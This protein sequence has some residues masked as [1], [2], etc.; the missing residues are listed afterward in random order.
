MKGLVALVFIIFLY[1][2]FAY[3]E[4]ISGLYQE[5]ESR[6]KVQSTPYLL[7]AFFLV[8]VNWWLEALK[9]QYLMKP[10]QAT[11]LGTAFRAVLIGISSS[12]FTPNRIGEYLG[13]V[14]ATTRKHRWKAAVALS[15]GSLIQ[16]AIISILGVIALMYFFGTDD[17]HLSISVPLYTLFALLVFALA[18]CLFFIGP[19]VNSFQGWIEK[20]YQKAWPQIQFLIAFQ[21]QDLGVIFLLTSIR[22][23]VY[24]VQY[25][26]LIRFFGVNVDSDLAICM[27]LITYL[28]QT[29]LPL[30]LLL[31]LM[32]RGEI[33]LL[34]WNYLGVNELSILA[35]SYG[36]WVINVVIP[37]LVGMVIVLKLE[38]KIMQK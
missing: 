6:L 37:A 4:N 1:Y 33:T 38:P 15:F 7:L 5:F 14:F 24:V 18:S 13:R 31:G 12:I 19:L 22:I 29:G 16:I 34:V 3:T 27:I 30:P 9:W 26:A 21:K 32:A 36:L 23:F 11:P 28:I 8:A 2:L 10:I 25:L 20:V 17:V 35:A